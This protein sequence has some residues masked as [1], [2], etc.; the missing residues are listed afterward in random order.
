MAA[1][2][3]TVTVFIGTYMDC[4]NHA[5]AA[6]LVPAEF[7]T[8]STYG[9]LDKLR[10]VVV[11]DMVLVG[12]PFPSRSSL[13]RNVR[14]LM[15]PEPVES[16]HAAP[17]EYPISHPTPDTTPER[18]G[19]GSPADVLVDHGPEPIRVLSPRQDGTAPD[20]DE[21]VRSAGDAGDGNNTTG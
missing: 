18:A 15:V 11:R 5:T 10:D 6:G 20:A 21:H 4:V 12:P 7:V 2:Q 13:E 8:I 19:S 9:D 16:A 1:H 3:R 17:P 14:A